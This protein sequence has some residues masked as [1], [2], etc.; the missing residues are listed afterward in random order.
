MRKLATLSEQGQQRVPIYIYSY[1]AALNELCI[2]GYLT[3]FFYEKGDGRN[4]ENLTSVAGHTARY[5][6]DT[7]RV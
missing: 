7:S 1:T 4:E 3:P 2:E 5:Y 6:I